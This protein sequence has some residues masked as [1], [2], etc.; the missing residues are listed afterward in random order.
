MRTAG[1]GGPEEIPAV[2][3]FDEIDGL[4]AFEIPDE[5]E[6]GVVGGVERP[7]VGHDLV[8]PPAEDVAHPADDVPMIGMGHDGRGPD[9][10]AEDAVVVV[11]DGH[12]PLRGDDAAL[13]LEDLRDE[14]QALHPVGLHVDH[15]LER[16]GGE[17]VRVRGQVVGRIGVIRAA[18]ELHPAVELSGPVLGGPVEHHVLDEVGRAGQARPLVARADAE[19]RVQ[20]DVGDVVVLEEEDLKPVRR[21]CG[22]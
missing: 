18:P 10:L 12:P 1:G 13:G 4:P 20:G 2:G 5:D 15:G 17:P 8:A 16:R 21:A 22:P 9:V 11:L 14:R 6:D 3:L 19:E 7:V